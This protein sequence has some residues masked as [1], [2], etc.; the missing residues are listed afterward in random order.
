MEINASQREPFHWVVVS[1][2]A[3]PIAASF[4]DETW[5]AANRL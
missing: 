3:T 5:A 2:A 4:L 1:S